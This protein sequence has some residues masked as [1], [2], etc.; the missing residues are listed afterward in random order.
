MGHENHIELELKRGY[1][2]IYA[3]RALF[4]NARKESIIS[5]GIAA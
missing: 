4:G 5:Y 3:M 1:L 2:A